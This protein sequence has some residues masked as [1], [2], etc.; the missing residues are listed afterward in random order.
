MSNITM[1]NIT[2][3]LALIGAV[4]FALESWGRGNKFVHGK[5]G[6]YCYPATEYPKTI[7]YPVFFS[8]LSAC[9]ESLQ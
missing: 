9:K 2:F 8:T 4:Y 6:E 1:R 3:I 7:K 5:Y